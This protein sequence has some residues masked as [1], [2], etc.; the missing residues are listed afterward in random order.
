MEELCCLSIDIA[1]V[2]IVVV[3]LHVPTILYVYI[4]RE[5]KCYP[6]SGEREHEH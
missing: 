6:L 4:N 1:V 2:V 5:S 3:A